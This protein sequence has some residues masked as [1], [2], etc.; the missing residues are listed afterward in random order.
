MPYTYEQFLQNTKELTKDQKKAITDFYSIG[1]IIKGNSI[2][3]EGDTIFDKNIPEKERD[4]VIE[5]RKN[6][7]TAINKSLVSYMGDKISSIDPKDK[8]EKA[9]KRYTKDLND[10]LAFVDFMMQGDNFDKFMDR[11]FYH[12]RPT[13]DKD[14]KPYFDFL[15]VLN[16]AFG[17][18][19]DIDAHREKMNAYNA[20]KELEQANRKA[21]FNKELEKEGWDIVKDD[22][23][24]ALSPEEQISVLDGQMRKT[25]HEAYEKYN[26]G[27]LWFRGSDEYD[28]ISMAFNHLVTD[29]QQ[30][31]STDRLRNSG[32]LNAEGY[33]K[34]MDK[35]I[36]SADKLD[37]MADKYLDYKK[38]AKGKKEWKADTSK[39]TNKN[40]RK[41]IEAANKMKELAAKI[42]ELMQK[43]KE[44]AI[45]Q[46]AVK[47]AR[48]KGINIDINDNIDN[49]DL[50]ESIDMDE[51]LGVQNNNNINIIM[52]EPVKVDEPQQKIKIEDHNI[53][54][55]DNDKSIIEDNNNKINEEPENE[56]PEQEE[57][58]LD[59]SVSGNEDPSFTQSVK[60]ER[61]MIQQKLDEMTQNGNKL[62]PKAVNTVKLALAGVI[63]ASILTDSG[64]IK[65][66]DKNF[67]ME[68]TTGA[69]VL[70]GKKQL[71]TMVTN[72]TTVDELRELSQKAFT[73]NG[74]GLKFEYMSKVNPKLTNIFIENNPQLAKDLNTIVK[75]VQHAVTL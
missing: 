35:T 69:K 24:P 16:D 41:R 68:K 45:K 12:R 2:L 55:I 44:Y 30:I 37:K 18:G 15:T 56:A 3:L 36:A 5:E 53:D 8:T 50:N 22:E 6:F 61:E 14:A 40:A 34:F 7:T 52:E 38:T 71:S 21:E 59:F 48:L 29:L 19:I 70:A 67:S 75:P 51:S 4:N 27:Q 17:A 49:I 54:N 46:D 39:I 1:T 66:G 28:D 13:M 31:K 26:D 42:K 65:P 64:K 47:N 10:C 11:A 60:Y 72:C 33:K 73:K 32:H 62:E 9:A 43:K 23:I 20:K 57:Q 74:N 25:F 63:T 58:D